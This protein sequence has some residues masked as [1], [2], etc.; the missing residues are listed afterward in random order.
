MGDNNFAFN[1][2]QN[3][4]VNWSK[5]VQMQI[6]LAIDKISHNLTVLSL[7]KLDKSKV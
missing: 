1:S 2:S 6:Q 3:F 4:E 5:P 7:V